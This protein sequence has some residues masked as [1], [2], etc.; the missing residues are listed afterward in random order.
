MNGLI[1][2]IRGSGVALR[3]EQVSSIV[4]NAFKKFETGSCFSWKR[5]RKPE[6]VEAERR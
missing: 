3:F 4:Q 2:L 6:I 1:S 5:D